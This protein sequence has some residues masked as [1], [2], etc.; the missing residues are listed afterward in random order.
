M[1]GQMC[2]DKCARTNA[3]GQIRKD[4]CAHSYKHST[5]W[6]YSTK[7][8]RVGLF[9]A[10]LLDDELSRVL[11]T[12][13][14]N[15]LGMPLGGAAQ[16]VWDTAL[17]A[18]RTIGTQN[19][20]AT[21]GAQL[22]GVQFSASRRLL[23]VCAVLLR[24]AATLAQSWLAQGHGQLLRKLR[25]IFA[26][27]D[28]ADFLCFLAAPQNGAA[29]YLGV[30]Y[31]LLRVRAQL[32]LPS[33]AAGGGYTEQTRLASLDFENRQLLWNAML[34]LLNTVA[35]PNSRRIYMAVR[36]TRASG[37]SGASAISA[38]ANVPGA[39]AISA[40]GANEICVCALCAEQPCNPYKLRCCGALYCYACACKALE[41]RTCAVCAHTS[42]LSAVPLYP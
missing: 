27:A 25:A 22:S 18:A 23:Y 5:H 15:A 2:K 6:A 33:G 36:G 28:L 19:S 20:C 7:M 8:S 11:Q 4:K 34:E 10:R 12:Q 17:F 9:Y 38:G 1:Q 32:A 35:L 30:A 3:Q 24:H 42:D 37:A 21:Y 39:N 16:L 26:A 29:Q 41:W 40:S 14:Q 31:R 13:T